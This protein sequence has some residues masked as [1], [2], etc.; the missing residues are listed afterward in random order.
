[1]NKRK[2][3]S[4]FSIPG[5]AR[6]RGIA[7]ILLVLLTGLSATVIALGTMSYVR[8]SQRSQQTVHA[9]TQSE[10]NAWVG[11]QALTGYLNNNLGNTAV[12]FNNLGNLTFSNTTT[13]TNAATARKAASCPASSGGNSY[14]CFDVTGTSA[15]SN[16]TLEVAYHFTQTNGIPT[17][18]TPIVFNGSLSVTGGGMNAV[19]AGD[20]SNIAVNGD[21]T[22]QSAATSDVSGCA[23]G[24]IRINGGGIT[25]YGHLYSSGGDIYID[26]QSVT[27]ISLWG[28]NVTITGG[29]GSY[30]AIKGNG[31]ISI[32]GASIDGVEFMHGDNIL[33]TPGGKFTEVLVNGDYQLGNAG[34]PSRSFG[35]LTGGGDFI[36]S[37]TSHLPIFSQPS[38][39]AGQVR[40]G[41]ASGSVYSG[42]VDKLSVNQHVSPG[43]PG[44][45]ACDINTTSFDV[46]DLIAQANYIF[47]F[48][49]SSGDPMLKIQN[50]NDR[51]GVSI[52]QTINLKE[53]EVM[54]LNSLAFMQCGWWAG[55]GSCGKGGNATDGWKFTGLYAFPPGIVLFGGTGD[56]AQQNLQ[57]TVFTMD[58]VNDSVGAS[59]Y[60]TLL[61]TGDLTLGTGGSLRVLTAP[62]FANAS[63]VCD[64]DFYPRQLCDKSSG[65]SQIAT[66]TDSDGNLV[67]LYPLANNAIMTNKNF[68]TNSWTITGHVLVG[69]NIDTGAGVTTIYGGLQV[70]L[71]TENG[72]STVTAGGLNVDISD[73]SESELLTTQ[74]GAAGGA[75]VLA[76]Y[77]VRM[78]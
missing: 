54:T 56:P 71:N 40:V 12:D 74:G 67:P 34:V 19:G 16:T 7:A 60:N 61:S 77:Q 36:V 28:K 70:G 29:G 44:L 58:G 39:I 37:S 8:G 24:D 78:L 63:A 46:N 1:M 75:R 11:M 55:G 4:I 15:N 62:N 76:D 26:G 6:Q 2:E 13:G 52:D 59:L 23:T 73:L 64:G 53:T 41:S 51:N 22:I 66:T 3:T 27:G 18:S 33:T 10:I 69:E 47:Y 57:E 42:A 48:D 72:E 25:D 31:D 14:V 45:P 21:L 68:S 65:Q 5:P 49:A 35:K 50:V 9:Q 20:L 17:I 38:R 30:Q 43:L 32:T